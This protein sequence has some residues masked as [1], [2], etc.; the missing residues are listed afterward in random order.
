MA[1]G[2]IIVESP[3]KASTISKFLKN[4]YTVKA[5]F[6]HVRDLPKKTLG[7]N[8]DKDFEPQYVIDKT[9]TKIIGELRDA[10]KE[11]DSVYLASDHD[12]EGEAI[13]WH[14]SKAF[15]KELKGKPIYRIVFNEITSKAITEAIEKPGQIDV[16]KVDAQ[17]ARRVLDRIVGYSVS[18]LL[19]KVIAKDLSAGRVQSVAL[20]LVCEREA[21]INAFVPK[22]FWKIEADFWKGKLAPFKASLEKWDGK[23]I[24][25]PDEKTTLELLSEL[26]D[27]EAVLSE[28]KRSSRA[29]EPPPPFITSTLQQEASKLLNMQATRTMS[30]A[31]QLYEGIDLGAGRRRRRGGRGG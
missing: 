19:W 18:P 24:E 5:S 14:L 31:Q 9:K 16:A 30:V 7:V 25:I 15:E 17:Q 4:K 2:L 11:A 23:K 3:A 20:R 29:I 10:V 21:E 12:R 26:K 1:K 13:A 22:E 27:K 6:G 8:V 28:I